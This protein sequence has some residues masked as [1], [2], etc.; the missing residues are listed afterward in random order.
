MDDYSWIGLST[1]VMLVSEGCLKKV[2]ICSF[3]QISAGWD[4]R[5]CLWNLEEGRC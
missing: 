5:L 2:I 1:N 3:Y 4:R